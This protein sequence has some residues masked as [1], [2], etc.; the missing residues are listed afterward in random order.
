MHRAS[1]SIAA[2]A[3]ALA[4]AQVELANPEKSLSAT[5]RSPFPREADRT[6]RYAS[7]AAGFDIARKC[8]GQHEIAVVQ[9]TMIGRHS[10]QFQLTT[11]LAHASGEWIASD[12]PV[13]PISETAAPHRMGA[14][15]TYARR[16]TLFAL[17]GI[18]FI[19]GLILC[20]SLAIDCL[21][22]RSRLRDSRRRKSK[23]DVAGRA[24]PFY[25]TAISPLVSVS[26]AG[27]CQASR[28]AIATATAAQTL[29]QLMSERLFAMRS[30][31]LLEIRRPA[32]FQ[33]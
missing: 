16:Y 20:E 21:E 31:P 25:R 18:S 12:W 30:L 7:L 26:P 2:I 24:Q 8:L 23:T 15:L 17:V 28:M 10:G 3:A 19:F 13:C 14:T 9:T 32:L 11:W 6:F 5:I 33:T 29:G 1:D 4:K 27:V 22:S